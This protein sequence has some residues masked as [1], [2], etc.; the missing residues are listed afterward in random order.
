M[1]NQ[2]LQ[3]LFKYL[4]E[5]ELLSYN[6]KEGE[7][8]TFDPIRIWKIL[9]KKRNGLDLTTLDK[10]DYMK[11]LSVA[12][13]DAVNFKSSKQKKR[14][15]PLSDDQ[16]LEYLSQNVRLLDGYYTR[17]MKTTFFTKFPT[18]TSAQ[19]DPYEIRKYFFN[20]ACSLVD[21]SISDGKDKQFRDDG[22]DP[23]KYR[24]ALRALEKQKVKAK[25]DLLAKKKADPTND[26]DE[27]DQKLNELL[28][29]EV[30]V[31][32][33]R[34]KSFHRKSKRSYEEI[35]TFVEGAFSYDKEDYDDV[36]S[37]STIYDYDPL[38]LDRMTTGNQ[39]PDKIADHIEPDPS[40]VSNPLS[41]QIEVIA[42]SFGAY[43]EPKMRTLF[44]YFNNNRVDEVQ[45]GK[46]WSVKYYQMDMPK[47]WMT[48]HEID[49]GGILTKEGK[50]FLLMQYLMIAVS[51]YK[52]HKH[53]QI[54]DDTGEAL[55]NRD[56]M[57]FM[58][59]VVSGAYKHFFHKYRTTILTVQNSDEREAIFKKVKEYFVHRVNK[60]LNDPKIATALPMAMMMRADSDLM[61]TEIDL[62]LVQILDESMFS[63][64]VDRVKALLSKNDI[65]D[66]IGLLKD[67]VRGMKDEQIKTVIRSV[68]SASGYKIIPDSDKDPSFVIEGPKAPIHIEH[69]AQ[70]TDDKCQ[71]GV[72]FYVNGLAGSD[73]K[74]AQSFSKEFNAERSL[75]ISTEEHFS[76]DF[77]DARKRATNYEAWDLM[78][79]VSMI[80]QT[81]DQMNDSER[82]KIDDV[83]EELILDF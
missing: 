52:N 16:E 29:Q 27:E 68:L 9:D 7:P 8:I 21:T 23:K 24:A 57:V 12:V 46:M 76:Q 17:R 54:K 36:D 63:D 81:Y 2:L 22:I 61:Q 31:E 56:Q 75:V 47:L 39:I 19:A 42:Q 65:I 71:I 30:D 74:K 60:A 40:K 20:K 4:V 49:R 53:F 10:I 72:S 83:I 11:A 15:T 41:S 35:C 58:T 33:Y 66:D 6:F 55:L 25:K 62:D 1:N 69:K 50:E 26:W 51:V 82:E 73:L 5:S 67:V 59:L 80:Q 32:L 45:H 44:Q 34:D 77:K 38:L 70:K 28:A 37:D 48:F 3:K 43:D 18:L 13:F 79:I 14:G 78:D 64:F